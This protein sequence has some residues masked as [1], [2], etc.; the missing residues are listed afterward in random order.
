MQSV[1]DIACCT[2]EYW[3]T[4]IAFLFV[5][6]ETSEPN[7]TGTIDVCLHFKIGYLHTLQSLYIT[8]ELTFYIKY[9][10]CL[11]HSIVVF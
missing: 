6:L 5:S 8:R 2:D 11:E 7:L 1:Y 3:S 9:I 10:Y 4:K